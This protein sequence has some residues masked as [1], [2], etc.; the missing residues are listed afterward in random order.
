MNSDRT[1]KEEDKQGKSSAQADLPELELSRLEGS[2]LGTSTQ[3]TGWIILAFLL[4]IQLLSFHQLVVRDIEGLYPFS[5]DQTVYLTNAYESFETMRN[6]GILTGL[7]SALFTPGRPTGVLLQGEASIIYLFL[8]ASRSTSLL[9][10]FGHFALLQIVVLAGFFQLT[11]R[12]AP[13]LAANALILFSTSRYFWAGG[14]SDF[15]LDFPAQCLYGVALIS[16][17]CSD[18]FR[19]KLWTSVFVVG[20]TALIATRFISASYTG[21]ALVISIAIHALMTFREHRNTSSVWKQLRT[22]GFVCLVTAGLGSLFIFP[23]LSMFVNYYL[24]GH[25]TGPEKSI[26]A[27]EMGIF[28]R[29]SSMLFYPRSLALDHLGVSFLAVTVLYICIATIYRGVF[30]KRTV[31][32]VEASDRMLQLKTVVITGIWIAI[33]LI[34]F[35]ADEAKSPVVAGVMVVPVAVCVLQL[36]LLISGKSTAQDVDNRFERIELAT[37]LTVLTISCAFTASHDSRRRPHF[38]TAKSATDLYAAFEEIYTEIRQTKLTQPKFASDSIVDYFNA[39]VVKVMTYER[40]GLLVDT[41]ELLATTIMAIPKATA[42][43]AIE[44][45]DFA[46]VTL[47]HATSERAPAYPF[48]RALLEY[49]TDLLAYARSEMSPMRKVQIGNHIFQFFRRPH[50]EVTGISGDWLLNSGTELKVRVADLRSRTHVLLSGPTMHSRELKG[51][52]QCNAYVLSDDGKYRSPLAS[53]SH[54]GNEEYAIAIDVSTALNRSE[55]VLNIHL[56]FPTFFVPVERGINPD[57]RKLAVAAPKSVRLVSG[58]SDFPKALL[59]A[60]AKATTQTR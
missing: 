60:H 48:E 45:A 26:R 37:F 41:R 24:V 53:I 19:N 25:F 11:G 44:G 16:F 29:A 21:I 54:I 5:Y 40:T 39:P 30:V 14:L 2:G 43:S 1:I 47:P 35:T 46:M 6:D 8:G 49:R 20:V 13:G 34:L 27:A 59:A 15:R 7:H 51:I 17:L 28:D 3:K 36:Y 58:L 57:T 56:D 50:I 33:P 38:E 9:V 10:L 31:S 32:A 12:H 55:A 23:S 4:L 52:L 42:I 18:R 22:A